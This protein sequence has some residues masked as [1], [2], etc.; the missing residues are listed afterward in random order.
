MVSDFR[1]RWIIPPWQAD[2]YPGWRTDR[3]AVPVRRWSDLS[4]RPI[5]GMAGRSRM[6]TGV[7][8]DDEGAGLESL[9]ATQPLVC[10]LLHGLGGSPYELGRLP[11]ALREAG[12][13]ASAPTLTGH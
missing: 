9:A 12:F 7:E 2:G 3:N 6:R 11:E 8:A 13:L 1:R 10:L 4:Y 5:R